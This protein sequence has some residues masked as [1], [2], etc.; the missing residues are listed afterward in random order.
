LEDVVVGRD[1]SVWIA[2][3]GTAGFRQW[4]VLS[5]DGT[6]TATAPLPRDVEL[7]DVWEDGRVGVV[8]DVLDVPQDVRYE[9]WNAG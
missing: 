5:G 1:A 7:F 8:R 6:V 3:T 2:R 9:L 4:V